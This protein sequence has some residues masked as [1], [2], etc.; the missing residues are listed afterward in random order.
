LEDVYNLLG[1]A[2]K[3]S[4]AGLLRQALFAADAF[5][6]AGAAPDSLR[7]V[8][9][10]QQQARIV[11]RLLGQANAVVAEIAVRLKKRAE[12]PLED[13]QGRLQS[14]FGG[15]FK[16]LPLLARA[17][18]A[19]NLFAQPPDG[20]TA[21]AARTWL[22]QA[23]RVRKGVQ[24]LDAA[25]ACAAAVTEI[26]DAAPA[27]SLR[28]AQLSGAAGERWVALPCLP[29]ETI[30]GG[31]VSIVAA[32]VGAAL[33]QESFAGLFIDEWV[34]VVPSG[35]ETTSV[36]F[37]CEAPTATAPQTL[38]IGVPPIGF[39]L[40]TPAAARDVVVE[41]LALA[42]L[43]LVDT[44]VLPQLGQLLPAFFTAEN[45]AGDA[46]GLDVESLTNGGA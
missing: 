22:G 26:S 19:G 41:A 29:G 2:R 34:D 4:D 6:I 25:L 3:A 28:V 17:P 30:P 16:V 10:P 43:R 37:H 1:N 44:D 39:E 11:E 23:A 18:A 31:R 42:Q 20:A 21:A 38:L 13:T 12:L 8:A 35:Q 27:A 14:I 32:A 7:D 45:A 40:W 46:A 9:D 36:A 24:L 5:S 15:G 33:E